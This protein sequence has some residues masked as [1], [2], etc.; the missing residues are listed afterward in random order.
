[1]VVFE[2]HLEIES[3]GHPDEFDVRGEEKGQIK[4][5]PLKFVS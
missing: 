5:S 2:I 1:M 4:F 3:M